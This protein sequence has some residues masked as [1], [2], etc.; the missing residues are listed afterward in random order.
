MVVEEIRKFLE[1]NLPDSVFFEDPSFDRSIVGVIV[2]GELVYSLSKMVSGL[3][4]DDSISEE[5]A[6]EFI[7]ANTLRRLSYPCEIGP[8]PIVVD[9]DSGLS[10]ELS[11]IL[12][13]LSSGGNSIG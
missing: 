4:D 2:N 5:G 10:F 7:D 1:E 3:A 6:M 11:D 12:N 8:K 9:D 13:G